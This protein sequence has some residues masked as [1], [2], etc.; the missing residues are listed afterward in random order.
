MGRL[1][2]PPKRLGFAPRAVGYV[3][4]A[5]AE[6][7]RDRARAA[8]NNLR[9]LYRIKRWRDLRLEIL[10]RAGWMCQGCAEPHLLAGK[11][12]APNSPVVD[13]IEPHR[14]NLALF[15]DPSNLQ[16]VCKH[17]HDTEKQRAEHAATRAAGPGGGS[18]V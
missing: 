2:G 15:W 13:H 12:P 14:G 1:K 3:D 4:R 17:Y 11:A 18:K 6:R 10:T 16:A 9:H 8:G 7:A 5:E